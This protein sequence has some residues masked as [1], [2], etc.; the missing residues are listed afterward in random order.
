MVAATCPSKTIYLPSENFAPASPCK[1]LRA[2][3]CA[4]LSRPTALQSTL[5]IYYRYQIIL[6][7]AR[8]GIGESIRPHLKHLPMLRGVPVPLCPT[9]ESTSPT[10]HTPPL[11]SVQPRYDILPQ[12]SCR[13]LPYQAPL[14]S[15]WSYTHSRL[16]LSRLAYLRHPCYRTS[17]IVNKVCYRDLIISRS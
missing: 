2:F 10:S 12:D 16:S 5:L 13:H 17:I 8:Q 4:V 6:L 15:G 11:S 1:C 3:S 14:R 9:T 7:Y